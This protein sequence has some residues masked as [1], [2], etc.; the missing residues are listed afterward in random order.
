VGLLRAISGLDLTPG[1][2]RKSLRSVSV[3]VEVDVDDVGNVRERFERVE[4]GE[5]LV[6]LFLRPRVRK[7]NA[8]RTGPGGGWRSGLGNLVDGGGGGGG[9]AADGCIG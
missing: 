1:D 2:R 8:S 4:W 3:S 9:G 7:A 6:K 5:S